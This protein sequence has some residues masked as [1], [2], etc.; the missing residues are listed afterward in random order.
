[1]VVEVVTVDGSEVVE[2]VSLIREFESGIVLVTEDSEV[3][4]RDEFP[5]GYE[6]RVE[7]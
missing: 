2:N 3:N 1:M 5:L 7:L 4:L 6:I